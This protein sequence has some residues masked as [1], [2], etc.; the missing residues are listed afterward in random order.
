MTFR[1]KWSLFTRGREHCCPHSSVGEWWVAHRRSQRQE[2]KQGSDALGS[3]I[4]H[5]WEKNRKGGDA[6]GG[7]TCQRL[8]KKQ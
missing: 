8:V 1:Y 4:P 5:L 6:T 2:H 3:G 7:P